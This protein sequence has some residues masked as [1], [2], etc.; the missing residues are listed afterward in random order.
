MYRFIVGS[1]RIALRGTPVYYFWAVGP[2]IRRAFEVS[3]SA[4]AL[5]LTEIP[6]LPR[7][8]D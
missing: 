2:G 7:H 6:D 5:E 3:R 1:I 8:R 4:S